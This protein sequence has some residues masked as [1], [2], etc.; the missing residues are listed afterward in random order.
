M[1][2]DFVNIF[3]D[4]NYYLIFLY[5]DIGIFFML[6]QYFLTFFGEFINL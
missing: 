5:M 2:Y 3:A 1:L 4:Y 6:N